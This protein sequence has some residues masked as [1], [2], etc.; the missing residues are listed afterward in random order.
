M[1]SDPCKFMKVNKGAVSDWRNMTL[2]QYQ[3]NVRKLNCLM[4]TEKIHGNVAG[5]SEDLRRKNMTGIN[6]SGEIVT[7]T[8]NDKLLCFV[9][10]NPCVVHFFLFEKICSNFLHCVQNQSWR[11]NC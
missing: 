11:E 10:E 8:G 7:F 6:Y 5:F 2:Q 1:S 9:F 3:G 4:Q